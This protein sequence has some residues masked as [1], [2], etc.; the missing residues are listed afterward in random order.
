MNILLK[1]LWAGMVAIPISLTS[2]G[3]GMEQ[4]PLATSPTTTGIQIDYIKVNPSGYCPLAAELRLYLPGDGKVRASVIPKEN[5]KTPVQ[6]HT[7]PYSTGR[8]Q[9]I[10]VLGLYPDY[11]NKVRLT[12]CDKAGVEQA[13]TIVEIKTEPIGIRSMPD[14][15]RPV[16][17][18]ID[19]MEPG[20]NLVNFPGQG[21]NDTSICYMVDADGEIRWLLDWRKSEELV[22]VGIQCGISG[23][24]KDG[25]YVI[26]SLIYGKIY[27]VNALGE[28]IRTT[29]IRKLGYDFHHDVKETSTGNL[30]ITADK[31]GTFCPID[32]HPRKHDVIIEVNPFN[33]ELVKEWDLVNMLDVSRWN[34]AGSP[35]PYHNW[36]HNN[37]IVEWG[38]G[39]VAC[40]RF[41]GIFYYNRAG[42]LHWIISPHKDWGSPYQRYLL[43]PID[44]DGNPVTDQAVIN[45]E[46]RTPKFD[47][48][49][50][51]HAPIVMPNGHILAFD[52]GPDRNFNAPGEKYSRIVEYEVDEKNMTVRQVWSF[53]YEQP[54]YYAHS[55]SSVQYLPRT[56]HVLFA[57][58]LA[59]TLSNGVEGGRIM[60]IAP[61]TNE[62]V[63]ELEIEDAKGFHRA[64]RMPLY[65]Q[66]NR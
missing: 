13:D 49:W 52:N 27:V 29:D 55:R 46:K 15:F 20:L 38:D 64:Y 37:S 5:T 34:H 23:T 3:N 57:P 18:E 50:G 8:V 43:S 19:K 17:A 25:N 31:E 10:N 9:F 36:A 51:T 63:F 58:G 62:V 54:Q 30:I 39:Y 22:H 12:F 45:G 65:P 41:Q 32:G 48:T 1:S 11:L 59:N 4:G 7:F 66:A 28:V 33:G 21:D 6:E 35:E 16:K 56:K 2:C 40:A 44:E 53:G 61:Q 26:G 60:E 14:V 24:T 47:W 42:Q